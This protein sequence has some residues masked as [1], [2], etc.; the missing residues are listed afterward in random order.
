MKEEKKGD[1][2][3]DDEQAQV[4]IPKH[5]TTLKPDKQQSTEKGDEA[6]DE[7]KDVDKDEDKGDLKD[8]AT[9]AGEESKVAGGVPS[10]GIPDIMKIDP[11]D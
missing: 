3:V 9:P 5:G 2:D 1:A 7:A 8:D 4:Y 10:S 11:E 6:K